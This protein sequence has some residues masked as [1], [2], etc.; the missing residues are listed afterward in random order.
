MND[1]NNMREKFWDLAGTKRGN[2]LKIKKSQETID[3][4]KL[5]KA[6]ISKDDEVDYRADN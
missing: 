4:E 3:K 6:E 2:L 1:R 5:D